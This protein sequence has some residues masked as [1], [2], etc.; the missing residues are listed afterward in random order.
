MG[1]IVA[2]Y[3]DEE[4]PLLMTVDIELANDVTDLSFVTVLLQESQDQI[5]IT[6]VVPSTTVPLGTDADTDTEVEEANP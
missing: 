1:R 3:P 2:V 6:E 5:E 4:D